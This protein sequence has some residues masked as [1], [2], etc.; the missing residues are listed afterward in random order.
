MTV[1]HPDL[2]ATELA[3]DAMLAVAAFC[4]QLLTEP[5]P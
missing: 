5:S 2:D 3:A 4:D 1:D